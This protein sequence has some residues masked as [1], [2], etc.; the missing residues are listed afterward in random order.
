LRVEQCAEIGS[1]QLH[2]DPIKL[3]RR[4]AP[5]VFETGNLAVYV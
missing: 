5:R 1:R 2:L 3:R 4:L